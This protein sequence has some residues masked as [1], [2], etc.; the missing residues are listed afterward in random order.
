MKIFLRNFIKENFNFLGHK[1]SH[2]NYDKFLKYNKTFTNYLKHGISGN[3]LFA[4]L[5]NPSFIQ[6]LYTSKDKSYFKFLF[7]SNAAFVLRIG[8]VVPFFRFCLQ[9]SCL[10]YFRIAALC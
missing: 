2:I 6:N 3:N 1:I 5:L 4:K 9:R 7:W 8:M 10:D